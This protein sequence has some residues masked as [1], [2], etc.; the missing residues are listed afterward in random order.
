MRQIS[1]GNW[2]LTS[3]YPREETWP[4][5]L[6]LKWGVKKKL[7]LKAFFVLKRRE[8]LVAYLQLI[9][10]NDFR[11]AVS[12][13]TAATTVYH[14]LRINSNLMPNVIVTNIVIIYKHV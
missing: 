14:I 7:I 12:S 11:A 9:C 5:S 13:L 2:C 6:F 3:A 8:S 10:I 1:A 4:L